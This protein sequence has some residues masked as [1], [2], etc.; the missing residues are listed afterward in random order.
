VLL[1]LWFKSPYLRGTGHAYQINVDLWF[2]NFEANPNLF[3]G[4]TV[5]TFEINFS[6]YSYTHFSFKARILDIK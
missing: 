2:L 6:G 3:W 5:P 1:I 4:N